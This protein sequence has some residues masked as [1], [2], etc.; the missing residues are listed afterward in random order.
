MLKQ[1]L[2][3]Q[4]TFNW[5]HDAPTRL[6]DT[7]Q[8]CLVTYQVIFAMA[9]KGNRILGSF[10]L[11]LVFL[12]QPELFHQAGQPPATGHPLG[13]ID[14]PL[15]LV[16]FLITPGCCIADGPVACGSQARRLVWVPPRS[17]RIKVHSLE[18]VRKD[19]HKK[20][21][22]RPAQFLNLRNKTLGHWR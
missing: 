4:L 11:G 15:H 5:S 18:L 3:G 14:L 20:R 21:D 8:A 1:Y 22:S 6:N 7:L 12:D 16:C 10:S 13:V 19:N 2:V 17:C 9:S